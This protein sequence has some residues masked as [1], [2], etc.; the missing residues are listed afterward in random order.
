MSLFFP[1]VPP[2]PALVAAIA[3]EMLMSLLFSERLAGHLSG[4]DQGGN[5][6]VRC[7]LLL[8]AALNYSTTAF[9]VRGGSQTSP[10]NV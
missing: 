3:G 5:M 10:N 8:L 6:W 2:A 7:Y 4:E 1:E 9:P